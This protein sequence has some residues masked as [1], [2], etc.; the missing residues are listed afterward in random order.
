[1]STP[2]E[3]MGRISQEM[4]RWRLSSDPVRTR[5]SQ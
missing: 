1:M 5:S 3:S 4:P 2:G